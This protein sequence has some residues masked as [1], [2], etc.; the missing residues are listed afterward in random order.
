METK[1]LINH[2]ITKWFVTVTRPI[3]RSSWNLNLGYLVSESKSVTSRHL[4]HSEHAF[5]I[6]EAD[7]SG[8]KEKGV[9]A[10]FNSPASL[11]P[12]VLNSSYTLDSLGRL[13]F[14]KIR[15]P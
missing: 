9:S 2:N 11:K 13:R 10:L 6:K 5:G 1:E 4:P 12:V 7:P 8:Q 15:T 14:F 3:R